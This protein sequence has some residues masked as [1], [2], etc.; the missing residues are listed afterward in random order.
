M[1]L[2]DNFELFLKKEKIDPES[3]FK[4]LNFLK[5]KGSNFYGVNFLKF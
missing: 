2:A 3:Y 5:F 1:Y 4:L